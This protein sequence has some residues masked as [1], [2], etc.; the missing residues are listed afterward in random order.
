MSNG[1]KGQ[2]KAASVVDVH[3]RIK[4]GPHAGRVYLVAVAIVVVAFV[5]HMLHII[6]ASAVIGVLVVVILI[7]VV[8]LNAGFVAR[9]WLVGDAEK[10]RGEVGRRLTPDTNASEAVCNMSYEDLER[11][12]RRAGN[13]DHH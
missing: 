8:V 7:A 11:Q 3:Q 13:D 2:K 9:L 10:R 6:G 1:K 4:D 12:Q 5:L